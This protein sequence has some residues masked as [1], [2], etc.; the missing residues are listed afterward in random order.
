MAPLQDTGAED[1]ISLTTSSRSGFA[2]F[3]DHVNCVGEL[4]KYFI[5]IK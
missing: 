1:M 2:A 4:F 5:K 3:L